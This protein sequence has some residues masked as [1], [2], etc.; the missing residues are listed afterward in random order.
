M[1]KYVIRSG[2]KHYSLYRVLNIAN[3]KHVANLDN[4]EYRNMLEAKVEFKK[5][6][7]ALHGG[8]DQFTVEVRG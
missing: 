6:L 4:T 1:T 5:M 7:K 2:T 8:S 3:C